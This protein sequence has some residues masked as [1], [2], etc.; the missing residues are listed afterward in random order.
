MVTMTAQHPVNDILA[1]RG[2]HVMY[3]ILY[4]HSV[5]RFIQA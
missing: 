3:T 2:Y 5:T 1:I 4:R